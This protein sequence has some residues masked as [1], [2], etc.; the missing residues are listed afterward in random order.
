MGSN[1]TKI[2]S[3]SYLHQVEIA[4][5]I[6]EEEGIEAIMKNMQD[7]FYKFGEIELYVNN[8][9]VIKAKQIIEK[10]NL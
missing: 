5:A 3:S 7:S 2:Y 10:A 1:W 4:K 6:L 8:E 9:S